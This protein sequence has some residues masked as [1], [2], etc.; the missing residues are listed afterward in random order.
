ML[1]LVPLWLLLAHA[2]GRLSWPGR[3]GVLY[4]VAVGG[5]VGRDALAPVTPLLL[6]LL[7]VLHTVVRVLLPL[8]RRAVPAPLGRRPPNGLPED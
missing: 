6:A 4:L 1:C 5:W 7:V 3:W 8:L 2:G